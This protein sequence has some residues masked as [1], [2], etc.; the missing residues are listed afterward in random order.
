MRDFAAAFATL[1]LG[2]ASVLVRKQ[3][4]GA[5]GSALSD[6]IILTGYLLILKG[7]ASFAGR[8]YSRLS[9]GL[10][11][12]MAIV[13]SVSGVQ[14][15]ETM[16]NYISSIPIALISALT[17]YEV[18]RCKALSRLPSR[19]VIILVTSIHALFYTCRA[20]VL[21][22]LV[23]HYGPDVLVLFSKI[24]I[25][26]GVLYSVVLPMT[27]L[28]LVREESHDQLLQESHT[29][30]LTRLGNRRRFFEEGSRRLAAQQHG[31]TAVLAFH[32]DQFKL[33]NDRY[34][35]QMG[36]DVLK[37]FARIV[38]DTF[39]HQALIARIGGEEF[40]ALLLG[41]PARQAHALGNAVV[42]HLAQTTLARTNDQK[43]LA[44]V[45]IGL[46]YYERHAPPLGQSLAN[47]DQALYRAKSAGGNCLIRS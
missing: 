22:W 47:A 1:A 31:P 20:V 36:D 8:R 30:Y 18:L 14:G 16:W 29:D 42:T 37:S 46:A 32:L 27:L 41:E 2:R 11:V 13:W 19:G 15:Q 7:V 28:K 43:I 24:T 5:L 4:P 26:E 44:T 45:S 3:L 9:V 33:I 10:L 40:A 23:A 21:P 35:H 39:G 25:Y 17:A 12:V 6:L 34:G 38:T